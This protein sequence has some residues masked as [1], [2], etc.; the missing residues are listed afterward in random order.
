VRRVERAGR[1]RAWLDDTSPTSSNSV[2]ITEARCN[3]FRTE[4]SKESSLYNSNSETEPNPIFEQRY[5]MI[6]SEQLPSVKRKRTNVN[7]FHSYIIF[8]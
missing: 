5:Q 7:T 2:P 6:K 4:E 1:V 8:T 3:A